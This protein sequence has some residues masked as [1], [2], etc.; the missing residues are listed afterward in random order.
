MRIFV[1]GFATETNTFSPVFADLDSFRAS[2]YAPPGEHPETPTLCTAP[3]TVARRR[4]RAEGW[5]L[6]EGTTAFAD[7]AG[8]LSRAAYEFLRDTILGEL[9]AAMP[10][11]GVLLCLHGAM[12]A[13]GADDPEGELLAGV[14]QI[15]G[16]TARIGVSIDPHSHLTARRVANA[17]IIAAFKEFPHT[18]FVVVAEQVVDLTLRA[19]R[20]EIRPKMS[21]F[22]C[23]MIDVF[24]TNR[25]PMRAFVDRLR[26]MEGHNGVLSLSLIH[27]F[28]AGDVPEMGTRM[29]VVTDDR[30]AEGAELAEQLGRAVFE[31]RGKARPEF[32]S[33]DAA[34]DQALASRRWPAVI[35]DAWDNPGGGV[36][37]DST[38]ILRRLLER[39]IRDAAVGSIWDPMAVRLCAIA[40]E[41]AEIPLRFG[42]K[43]APET[44]HPID[45]IVKV[46]KVVRSAHQ[47]FGQSIVPIGD[48]VAVEVEGVAVVLNSTRAQCFE[49]T[50]FTNL[51]VD[52]K[53]R[54]LLVVKSTNHF[55][56]AFSQLTDAIYYCEAGRPYP[57]D[58]RVTPFRKARLDIWPRVIAPFG[59]G[60]LR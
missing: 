39:K 56:A 1:A 58:P 37:G 48:A 40:G 13:V 31:M 25:Q 55:F 23:R 34:I 47:S 49:P 14:R 36:A 27:G 60:D 9:R 51:G 16:Q 43:T 46:T 21:V 52:P 35:A 50:L 44:G 2:L 6:I 3:L 4:S 8:L 20:G 54:R 12:V 15:V 22:D 19:V 41:G 45:A 28:M 38:I 53:S 24:M 59:E 30:E 29:L 7:P 32:L 33:P 17:D 10:V 5:T 18:D 42:A 11:D 26:A 57:N